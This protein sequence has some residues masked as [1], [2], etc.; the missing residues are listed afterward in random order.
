ML[1][2]KAGRSARRAH[3][4]SDLELLSA[5]LGT[6]FN[7]RLARVLR[8][9]VA[10]FVEGQDMTILRR[11]AK[12]LGLTSLATGTGVTVIPLK[13]YSRWSHVSPFAWLCQNLLPKA[14]TTF[15]VLDHDYRPKQV[16]EEI[17]STFAAEG[18]IA[19]VWNRKELESYL[20]TPRVISR[21]SGA[22]EQK[23][24]EF[25]DEITLAME[26][27]VFGKMLSERIRIERSAK[28]HESVIMTDFKREFD[29]LW[30]D[31]QFRLACCPA[32]DVISEL[33]NKLKEHS[34]KT[35]SR[36]SLASQHRVG[37]IAQEMA[38]FLRSVEAATV[39]GPVGDR[40]SS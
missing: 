26:N 23:V 14:L 1:I 37:D 33:N 32:K 2:E 11:F 6:A 3:E 15:V 4:E 30:V 22:S 35:V 7:L 20:L 16:S 13:G 29:S 10:L 17:E 34:Y 12:T 19:H 18:V 8:S 38:S 24:I 27:D 40:T 9:K 25:L 28:R 5:A 21:I 39:K 36:R 31:R